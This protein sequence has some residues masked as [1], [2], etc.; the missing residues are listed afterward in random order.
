MM[1]SQTDVTP[2]RALSPA[3]TGGLRLELFATVR[4]IGLAQAGGPE[5]RVGGQN[6]RQVDG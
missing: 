3:L 6:G 4:P 2:K 1:L 5:V